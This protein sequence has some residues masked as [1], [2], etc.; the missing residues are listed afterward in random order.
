MGKTRP[1]PNA[2]GLRRPLFMMRNVMPQVRAY[3]TD[4]RYPDDNS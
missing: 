4:N 2:E 1:G 3:Y